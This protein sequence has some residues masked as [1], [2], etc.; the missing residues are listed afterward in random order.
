MIPVV[1]EEV[2]VGKELQETGV[3]EILKSVDV[4]KRPDAIDLRSEEVD[5][6]RESRQEILE[7]PMQQWQ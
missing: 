1:Q 2:S 7:Q 6:R 4:E 5:I 3:V